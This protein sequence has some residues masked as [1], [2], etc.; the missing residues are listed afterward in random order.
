MTSVTVIAGKGLGLVAAQDFK[1]GDKI[2]EEPVTLICSRNASRTTQVKQLLKQFRRLHTVEKLKVKR[3][4]SLGGSRSI[5]SIFSTNNFSINSH[6]CGLYIKTSRINHS[7]APNAVY[8][9]SNGSFSKQVRALRSISKGEEISISYT[10]K[11]WQERVIRQAEL[12]EWGFHCHCEVCDMPGK[13]RE[14]NDEQRRKL[15]SLGKQVNGFISKVR[16]SFRSRFGLEAIDDEKLRNINCDLIVEI[17]AVIQQAEE[18]AKIVENLKNQLSLLKFPVL[19]DC[20]LLYSKA[21]SLGV[22]G[23]PKVEKRIMEIGETLA[24]MSDL[25][26]DWRNNL[27]Q[28][29]VKAYLFDV[30]W[31]YGV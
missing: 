10:D 28:A 14:Y 5:F 2:I 9:C 21:R 7:C 4:F 20:L 15:V 19:L 31:T 17:K 25:N 8:N 26:V 1:A 6:C 27:C 22:L 3:L 29:I 18:R 30:T 24:A 13:Q 12:A 16:T 11:F 23:G